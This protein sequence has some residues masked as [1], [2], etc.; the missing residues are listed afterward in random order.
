MAP[1]LR[2]RGAYVTSARCFLSPPHAR[3]TGLLELDPRSGSLTLGDLFA[4]WG[5]PLT[6][7]RL[8]GFR[9]PRAHASPRT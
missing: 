8:A 1:P 4:I 5:Q 3:T 2:A 9:A 6:A 7:S